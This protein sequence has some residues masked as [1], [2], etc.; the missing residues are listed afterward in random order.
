M[1]KQ[2]PHAQAADASTAHQRLI[3][4]DA[5]RGFAV[6]GIL[7]MNIIAFAMPQ[8]A[9]VSPSA[10]GGTSAL[11]VQLWAV[12][13]VLVDGKMRALF[14][15]LF[16]ASMLL[17]YERAE[18]A[19][20]DGSHV[21]KQRMF[22]LL[23]FGAVHNYFIWFGDIL[24]LYAACGVAG[25][26][27][28]LLTQ[29]Q[30]R[31]AA[32][33]LIIVST[34]YSG[35][36]FATLWIFRLV[37]MAIG[38]DPKAIAIYADFMNDISAGSAATNSAE[39]ALF[40]ASY[41]QITYDRL[42]TGFFDPLFQLISAAPETL[43]LMAIGMFL[44]RSGFLTGA[45]EENQYRKLMWRAYALGIPASAALTWWSWAS[46][47]DPLVTL[48]NMIAW[49]LPFR[50]AVAIGHASLLM[51][52]IKRYS[53]SAIIA[54]VVA[55][56]QAAFSNYLG[57]SILMTTLFYGYGLGWFGTISRAQAYAIVPFV[58]LIMLLWSKP[59]LDHYRYGPFEWLWRSL[60]RGDMQRMR[61]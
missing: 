22:W 44:F 41:P 32:L 14:S 5:I 46:G 27:L 24:T 37:A 60:A 30:L 49:S 61:R 50:I 28:L 54:R 55:T 36:M 18:A 38:T 57:T 59:W 39:I 9:Y 1:D 26:I 52:I 35:L 12:M 51:L 40:Q 20:G 7:L 58:W 25:M 29:A 33:W 11:D 23:I 8:A 56:G 43:G 42:T 16:G 4:L 10:F 17:V 13:S 34:V 45:W 19:N 31:R 48:G 3:S 6:M 2:E 21:H 53:N 15:M 47:F